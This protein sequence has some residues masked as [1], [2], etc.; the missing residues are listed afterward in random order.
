MPAH[1]RP[2]ITAVSIGSMLLMLVGARMYTTSVG[3]ISSIGLMAA[4]VNMCLAVTDRITQRRLLTFECAGLPSVICTI[5]NNT[6][7]LIP[8]LILSFSTHEFGTA[9]AHKP[10]W[11]DPRV[12][13]LLLLSGLVG[14]GIC[15]V[16]IVC[17]RAI[18]ATSF[19]V[20]QNATKVIIVVIGVTLFADPI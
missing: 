20:L 2:T 18:T 7:G 16:G 4:F 11:E 12:I 14:I 10:D 6:V 3:E 13:C 15:Y 5:L 17:Q 9:A 1:K 19:F 8:T